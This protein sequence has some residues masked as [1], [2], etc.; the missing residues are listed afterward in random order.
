MIV[1]TLHRFL[2]IRSPVGFALL[3]THEA[4]AGKYKT[5]LGRQFERAAKSDF[6]IDE[7]S[8]YRQSQRPAQHWIHVIGLV[9]LKRSEYSKCAFDLSLLSEKITNLVG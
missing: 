1:L 5:M 9:S 8:L 2:K 6:S 7:R 3:E 4:E